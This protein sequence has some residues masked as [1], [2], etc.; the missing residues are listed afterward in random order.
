M[1][2]FWTRRALWGKKRRDC[3]DSV[4]IMQQHSRYPWFAVLWISLSHLHGTYIA[5][6]SRCT[7]HQFGETMGD[8]SS[9]FAP[10]LIKDL[11]SPF[12]PLS[13][14]QHP[15]HVSFC[16]WAL[17]DAFCD[18]VQLWPLK[19]RRRIQIQRLISTTHCRLRLQSQHAN[20]FLRARLNLNTHQSKF[21][22]DPSRPQLL[23]LHILPEKWRVWLVEQTK[24]SQA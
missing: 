9:L 3:R 8:L 11:E 5:I 4:D 7:L 6:T 12:S 22:E 15:S 18:I 10:N 1:L 17:D 16:I 24:P 19:V 2:N 23:L 14:L 21:A 13:P 20:N